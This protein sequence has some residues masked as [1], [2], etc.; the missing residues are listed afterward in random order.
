MLPE[1]APRPEA[2]ATD[3]PPPPPPAS[4]LRIIT[5]APTRND[6]PY[7]IVTDHLNVDAE[8]RAF[9][10]LIA[11]SSFK[12]PLA[13]G[14]FGRWGSGKTFFMSRIEKELDALSPLTEPVPV[15]DR[16]SDTKTGNGFCTHVVRIRF[17][18]WHYMETN[19]WAS[20]V[21]VIFKQLDAWLRKGDAEKA[22]ESADSLFDS[23]STAQEMKL[24]AIEALADRL[25]DAE[26][27]RDKL[28]SAR[29]DLADK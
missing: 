11:S 25:R 13:I 1:S 29:R 27:A 2:E 16:S 28:A 12:P 26:A 7:S 18:A 17:N 23:L 14:I 9:A 8:A 24:E 3:T 20:L 22:H 5:T 21:D 19:V 15:E 6:D 10:R 4:H